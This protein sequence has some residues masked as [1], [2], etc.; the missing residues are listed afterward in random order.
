[1]EGWELEQEKFIEEHQWN[2]KPT[3]VQKA[4]E[5]AKKIVTAK[6]D[7]I[8]Q[9]QKLSTDH[10]NKNLKNVLMEASLMKIA[11]IKDQSQM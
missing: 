3:S 6:V 8:H 1:M 9:L 11:N 2:C 5:S 7:L 4:K 10:G